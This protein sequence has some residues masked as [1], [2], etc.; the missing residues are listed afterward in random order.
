[1]VDGRSSGG[2]RRE[3]GSLGDIEKIKE[4][5]QPDAV[6]LHSYGQKKKAAK[7]AVD[8]TRK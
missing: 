1:M 6:L 8:I 2:S 7:I 3:G 5:D 4:I